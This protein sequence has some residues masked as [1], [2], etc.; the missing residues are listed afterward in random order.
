[1]FSISLLILVFAVVCAWFSYT[2]VEEI[3]KVAMACLAILA[4]IVSLIISPWTVKISLLA[5]LPIWLSIESRK[6]K[7]FI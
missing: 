1:M 7:E 6:R 3:V 4:A 2:T 5:L